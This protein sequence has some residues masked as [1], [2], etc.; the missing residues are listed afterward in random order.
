LAESNFIMGMPDSETAVCYEKNV[1]NSAILCVC[2]KNHLHLEAQAVTLPL[3]LDRLSI[4]TGTDRSLRRI[5]AN[6]GCEG[7]TTTIQSEYHST[8]S[9]VT[10]ASVFNNSNHE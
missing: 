7:P 4:F 8:L 6:I 9:M 10:L 1:A 2:S 5:Y 3:L